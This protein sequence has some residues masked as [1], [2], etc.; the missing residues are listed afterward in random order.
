MGPTKR[1][2]T[3]DEV[4]EVIGCYAQQELLYNELIAVCQNEEP[5][6]KKVLRFRVIF[7]LLRELEDQTERAEKAFADCALDDWSESQIR[8]RYALLCKARE[9]VELYSAEG[10][11]LTLKVLEG[12]SQ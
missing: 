8:K 4:S 2:A 6:K 1:F 7:E 9:V 3:E 10:M 11:R 5:E 12:D